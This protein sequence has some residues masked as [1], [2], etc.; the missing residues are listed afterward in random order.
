MA[1][2]H[3]TFQPSIGG[4]V[5]RGIQAF[6]KVRALVHQRC[7]ELRSRLLQVPNVVEGQ[8]VRVVVERD[9]FFACASPVQSVRKG[10]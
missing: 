2:F 7:K 5:L 1:A 9:H 8:F 3:T 6:A 10:T 4:L